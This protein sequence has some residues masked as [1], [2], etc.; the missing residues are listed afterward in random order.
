MDSENKNITQTDDLL[1]FSL[2]GFE[3]I[4]SLHLC[5]DQS[6]KYQDRWW[7]NEKYR[8]L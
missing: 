8:N 6:Y 2:S 3:I 5:I 4:V 1:S 7:Q